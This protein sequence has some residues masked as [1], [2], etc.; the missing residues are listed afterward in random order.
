MQLKTIQP[1]LVLVLGKETAKFL[2]KAF[3]GE[4]DKW[5]NINRLKSFYENEDSVSTTLNFE[6]GDITFVFVIHPSLN[7]TNRS[8]IWGKEI[9]KTYEQ[10]ILN[11]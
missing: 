4:F 11:K 6:G 1:E 5:Q 3:A 8:R 2:C 10:Q 7:S 9:G